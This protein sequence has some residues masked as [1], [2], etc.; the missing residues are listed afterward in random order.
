M[1][2]ISTRKRSPAGAT[3]VQ[4]HSMCDGGIFGYEGDEIFVVL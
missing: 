2:S 3:T 4:I 1:S